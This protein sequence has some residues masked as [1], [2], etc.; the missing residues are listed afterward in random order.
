MPALCASTR[1]TVAARSP[2][3]PLRIGTAAGLRGGRQQPSSRAHSVPAGPRGG[4]AWGSLGRHM[5]RP[6]GYYPSRRAGPR[7]RPRP[8]GPEGTPREVGGGRR[9]VGRA[10]WEAGGGRCD[11]RGGGWA[12]GRALRAAGGGTCE[13]GGGTCDVGGG[14]WDVR[15]GRREVGRATWDVG[16]GTLWEW[17]VGRG[18]WD[19]G[20]RGEVRKPPPRIAGA[21]LLLPAAVA[22]PEYY[23]IAH[24][25]FCAT[26]QATLSLRGATCHLSRPRWNPARLR[27]APAG[28]T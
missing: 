22:A 23:I 27:T 5:A 28:P 12:V 10:T 4:W 9:E 1:R 19:T 21:R 20:T 2:Q 14:R 15:G 7:R 26:P 8:G 11:V 13:A 18:A 24:F 25:P 17:V 3:H 16:R 6:W